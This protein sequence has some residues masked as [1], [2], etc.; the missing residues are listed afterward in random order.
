M[1]LTRFFL[2]FYVIVVAASGGETM[3]LRIVNASR[4]VKQIILLYS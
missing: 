3:L 1:G 2:F 4:G